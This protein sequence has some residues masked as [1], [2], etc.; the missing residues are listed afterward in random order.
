MNEG[1]VFCEQHF[2]WAH[3][4][5]KGQPNVKRA[6]EHNW[7]NM[8]H[9]EIGWTYVFK[10]GEQTFHL[11]SLPL[12]CTIF[13]K[14]IICKMG[15]NDGLTSDPP[16]PCIWKTALDVRG[17]LISLLFSDMI[18]AASASSDDSFRRLL[19]SSCS[20]SL[21]TT[22]STLITSHLISASFKHF[23]ATS[24]SCWEVSSCDWDDSLFFRAASNADCND[25]SSAEADTACLDADDA[26]L[27]ALRDAALPPRFH[28]TLLMT[29]C[30]NEFNPGLTCKLLW[31]S[32][33]CYAMLRV[34]EPYFRFRL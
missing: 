19:P 17:E 31:L 11:S 4:D 16:M 29:C 9:G 34:V 2:A 15:W 6:R 24:T 5:R 26:W 13:F 1:I 12:A 30:L 10:M 18:G 21:I 28:G 23:S 22:E 8:E 25:F 20:C 32:R 33:W 7:V 3:W 27:L 14:C